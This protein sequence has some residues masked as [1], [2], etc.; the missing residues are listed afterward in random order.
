MNS[1]QDEELI[2]IIHQL[3]REI[4]DRR[5]AEKK[6]NDALDYA[7]SIIDSMQLPIVVIDDEERIISTNAAFLDLF[8]LSLRGTIG[9]RFSQI[10]TEMCEID[11]LMAL[12]KNDSEERKSIE[13]DYDFR[14]IGRKVLK[15]KLVNLHYNVKHLQLKLVIF[16]DVT[17]ERIVQDELFETLALKDRLVKEVNHRVRNNLQILESL[18]N[19]QIDMCEEARIQGLLLKNKNRIASMASVHHLSYSKNGVNSISVESIV[20]EVL[21]L[22]YLSYPQKVAVEKRIDDVALGLTQA[23]NLSMALN[24]IISNSFQHAFDDGSTTE[25]RIEVSAKARGRE[26]SFTVEDNGKGCPVGASEK[27]TLGIIL[28]KNIVMG[29]LKGSWEMSGDPGVAHRFTF[30]ISEN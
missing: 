6:A 11:K 4:S 14:L 5:W 29:N 20:D 8:G 24:E 27:Q 12:I 10:S 7:E 19:I 22:A 25:P 17:E 15:V 23:V 21:H 18:Y 3:K 28:I 16:D 26:V 9:K 13:I 30:A 2:R 1:T